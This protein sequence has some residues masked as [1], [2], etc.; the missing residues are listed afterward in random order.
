M[1]AVS[2]LVTRH[3]FDSDICPTHVTKKRHP[4]TLVRVRKLPH[5]LP[6]MMTCLFY[7]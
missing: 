7:T 4:Q 1:Y 6:N 3:L 2:D 5:I